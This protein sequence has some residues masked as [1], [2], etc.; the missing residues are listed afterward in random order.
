MK[1]I[2]DKGC[3]FGKVHFFDGLIALLVVVGILA[4]GLRFA[5]KQKEEQ[6]PKTFSAVYTLEMRDMGDLFV[7]AFAVGDTIYEWNEPIGTIKAV[8][9]RPATMAYVGA[10]GTLLEPEYKH[11]HHITLTVETDRMSNNGRY[12]IGT[13]EFL[14]GTGHTISNGFA[15]CQSVVRQITI[16]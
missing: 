11:R 5:P 8:E 13:V 3:L 10:E 16:K 9:V 6:K 12:F 15:Q 4:V 2:D 7:D 14:N 1:W